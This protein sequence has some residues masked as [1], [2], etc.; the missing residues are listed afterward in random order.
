MKLLLWTDTFKNIF[1]DV[2]QL[3]RFSGRTEANLGIEAHESVTIYHVSVWDVSNMEKAFRR[4]EVRDS[5]EVSK[6]SF[7]N[8]PCNPV[9]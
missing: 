8:P 9:I 5:K 4:W 6:V 1:K 7:L 3:R 2:K